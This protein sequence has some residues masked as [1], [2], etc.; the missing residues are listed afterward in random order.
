MG[1]SKIFNFF[2]AD[3][4]RALIIFLII[5]AIILFL[6]VLG[7]TFSIGSNKY[8]LVYIIMIN[9]MIT[10]ILEPISY[11][12]NWVIE[13][14]NNKKKLLFG[15]EN[16]FLC[17]AQS[18]AICLFQSSREIFVT[19]IS[20]ISFISFKYE[21][22]CNIDENKLYFI[23]FLLIGY[24]IP[25]IES[26]IYSVNKGF[27]LSHSFCFTKI[28]GNE[29]EKN[30]SKLC[31]T[32]HFGFVVILILISIFFITYLIIKT[33]CCNEKEEGS[34][35]D[36]DD[37]EDYCINPNLKKIIFFPIAQIIT[38]SLPVVY[39]VMDY[40]IK[41][42]ADYISGPAAVMNSV[43]SILYTL[44]FAISNGIFTNFTKKNGS[45]SDT[46]IGRLLDS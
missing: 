30:F 17:Q 4:S 42:D 45:R 38:M 29:N 33:T 21:N 6:I 23:I 12:L 2:F 40:I 19:S 18:F 11:V 39:R 7:I 25:L 22:K 32:I 26:I 46:G 36:N 8:K 3:I 14:E 5:I 13:D 20:I 35:W 44:V 16:G 9:V 37:T 27:G 1:H 34:L 15:E 10:A 24:F 43:S 41:I 28:S 31:G